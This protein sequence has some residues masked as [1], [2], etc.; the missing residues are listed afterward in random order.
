ME[1]SA[2]GH[3]SL[4]STQQDLARFWQA[5]HDR[6]PEFAATRW[7]QRGCDS[8]EMLRL[9]KNAPGSQELAAKKSQAAAA[10]REQHLNSGIL[11]DFGDNVIARLRR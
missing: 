9:L 5:L 11:A 7:Q 8:T 4:Q 6:R 2:E 10:S 1:N 3:M